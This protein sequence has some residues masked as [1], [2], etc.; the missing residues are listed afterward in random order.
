MPEG[1]GSIIVFLCAGYCLLL[2]ELFVPGGIIGIF[3]LVSVAY[4]CWLAFHL[5]LGWG[6]G[7]I[8]LSVLVFV[9]GLVAFL[10]NR[11]RKGLVLD[12][13][14]TGVADWQAAPEELSD[15]LG[16]QGVTLTPLRPAGWMALGDEHIDVVSDGEFLAKGVPVRVCEVE[17]ARVVVEAVPEAAAASGDEAET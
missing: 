17:G 9:I 2:V 1:L 13:E 4:G 11:A 12:N 15:L 14:R 16:R 8:G 7:S 6:F 5:S 10:K 3:G